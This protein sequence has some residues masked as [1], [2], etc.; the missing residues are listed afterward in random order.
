MRGPRFDRIVPLVTLVLVGLGVVF[1]LELNTELLVVNVGGSLPSFSVAWALI[2]V[3]ALVTGI[4]VELIARAHSRI[5]TS[6]WMTTVAL[7]QRRLELALPLWIVPALT[8]IAM[9]AFFRLF[10]GGLQTNAYLLVLV[11]TAVLLLL[12]LTAQHY[13]IEGDE[14]ARKIA[15]NVQSVVAYVLIFAIFSVITFNRYRTLYALLL[16]FPSTLLLAADLLRNR[17]PALWLAASGIALVLIESYWALN[18][19]PASFWLNSAALLVIFYVLV[20]LVQ[21][22]SEA[23]H[24]RAPEQA[25]LT[26][27]VLWEYG[28]LGTGAL[29]ALAIAT[30]V[31][32]SQNID[33]RGP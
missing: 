27:R 1:L 29:I 4:G 19:W 9:F 3:L 13:L 5:Y 2:S 28:L 25:G 23:A 30:A 18:Y 26:R 14:S 6:G 17:V 24:E 15:R 31:L 33:L 10:K 21:G 12:V 22:A 11:A 32:R 8:P 7:G 16:V 20:G